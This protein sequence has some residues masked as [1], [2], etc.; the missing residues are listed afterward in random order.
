[1]YKNKE[2]KIKYD[3]QYGLTHK[4]ERKIRDSK[5]IK[6]IRKSRVDWARNNPDKVKETKLKRKYNLTLNQYNE[7]YIEQKGV[8]A[9][10]FCPETTKYLGKIRQLCVDHNHSNGKVRGLLCSNCN[11]AAGL[12]KDSPVVCSSLVNYLITNNKNI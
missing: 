9:V 8:C 10:C 4:K 6:V 3:K 1:M 5:N 7:L 11:R 2:D 12:L